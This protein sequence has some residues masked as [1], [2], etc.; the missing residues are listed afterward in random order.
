MLRWILIVAGAFLGFLFIEASR[1]LFGLAL[2]AGLGFLLYSVWSLKSRLHNLERKIAARPLPPV[3]SQETPPAQESARSFQHGDSD[4]PRRA[5]AAIPERATTAPKAAD[6]SPPVVPPTSPPDNKGLFPPQP[7]TDQVRGATPDPTGFDRLIASGKDWLTTGNVPVKVGLIILFFGV[8]F[9]LKYAIDEELFSMPIQVRLLTVAA[10]G[11]AL[12]VFGWRLRTKSQVYAINL[13]GGGIGVLYLTIFAAF[14]LYDLLPAPA[15]FTLLVLLTIA[16]G[17]LSVMQNA[18]GLAVMASVGGFLA[19]VLASTGQGSHVALFSYYLLINAAILG[20]SWYRSWRSLNLVGF[21]FTFGV[22]TLWGFEYYTPELYASTQPFLI[23]NFLFYQLIAILFAFRQKPEL[24]GVVDGTIVFGTPVIAFSLQAQL[25]S[26]T[27]YGLAISAAAVAVFYASVAVWLYRL[28]SERMHLLRQSFTVLSVGFATLAVPLA[29]DDR[30]SAVT[31]AL[32]GAAVVWIGVRQKGVLA[33]IGGTALIFASGYFYLK[34]GWKEG[35]GMPVLN[36]NVLGGLI[37]SVA[38]LYAS[39]LLA[40][41]ANKL[42][43]QV[44]ASIALLVWGVCWWLVTGVAEISDRIAVYPYPA[45]AIV[46]FFSVSAVAMSLYARRDEWVA[47]RRST[48]AFVPLLLSMAPAHLWNFDHFLKAWG[49]FSWPLALAANYLV[50]WYAEGRSKR[51]LPFLHALSLLSLVAFCSYEMF[52]WAKDAGLGD[53]WRTSA[54]MLGMLA[55][56]ALVLCTFKWLS[57]PLGRHR[58]A[59]VATSIA[60]VATQLFAL[61]SAAIDNPGNPQPWAYVPIFNPFDLL[62]LFGLAAGFWC[63][64]TWQSI[65]PGNLRQYRMLALAIL[66]GLAF[67]LSTLAVVRGVHHFGDIAWN[68]FALRRSVSVQAALSIYW[69]LL[70]VSGMVIGI[71]RSAYLPWIVGVVLLGLVVLKMFFVDLGNSGTIARFV[72]FISVGVLFI[73][74][75]YFAPRPP[76]RNTQADTEPVD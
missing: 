70:G 27:E 58:L 59:Y 75:G 14:R 31:W 41:D 72:T 50:L 13:Q 54:A 71:R 26:N 48:Y 19:P 63:I 45:D 60:V 21:V 67:V 9:L 25:V 5:P 39:R 32:E 61:V 3:A 42:P 55:L 23:L 64:T 6:A 66:G 4:T 74:V 62:T 47:A 68:G 1:E 38:A 53:V 20:I 57:W 35:L 24:R 56:S 30:W 69:A 10:M 33:R 65:A 18:R 22:G 76:R 34:H 29:L 16:G 52:W 73:L 12:L 15:A 36:G 37:I 46:I 17:V 7:A 51:A 2:G 43:A 8:A 28:H 11:V 44:P 40:K 49:W